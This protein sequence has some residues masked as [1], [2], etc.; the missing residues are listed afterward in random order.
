[1]RWELYG[2]NIWIF[3]QKKE[4]MMN[5]SNII[6]F[7]VCILSFSSF[8]YASEKERPSKDPVGI[9]L[10]DLP[11]TELFDIIRKSD[12]KRERSDAIYELMIRDDASAAPS[13][14]DIISGSTEFYI[15]SRAA[16]T[17]GRIGDASIVSCLTN[18]YYS[19]ES[20]DH[21]KAHVICWTLGLLREESAVPT[22]L[23][24]L[25]HED[26]NVRFFAARSLGEIGNQ[27]AVSALTNIWVNDA[28]VLV[29]QNAAI[30]LGRLQCNTVKPVL[31]ALVEGKDP[32]Y[33]HNQY[34]QFYAAVALAYLNDSVGLDIIKQVANDKDSPNNLNSAEELVRLKQKSGVDVLIGMIDNQ[35][36]CTRRRA[37][38]ALRR[39]TGQNF[40]MDTKDWKKWWEKNKDDFKFK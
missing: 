2:G 19:V 32:A 25:R 7:C 11:M 13:L 28:Y 9:R 38:K 30:A 12:N 24:A 4:V 20:S 31:L 1:M 33:T 36:M 6:V 15:Y 3:P 17:L 18:L 21:E 14:F 35:N 22:L 8:G 26:N 40:G 27:R 10:H 16:D 37:L 23:D 29:R 39:A 34:W 5:K